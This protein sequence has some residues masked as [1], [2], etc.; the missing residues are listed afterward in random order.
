[1]GTW[2]GFGVTCQEEGRRDNLLAAYVGR[3]LS[4]SSGSKVLSGTILV[5]GFENHDISRTVCGVCSCSWDSAEHH[6]R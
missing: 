4:Y 2:Y 6:V 3:D 1:M 5:L